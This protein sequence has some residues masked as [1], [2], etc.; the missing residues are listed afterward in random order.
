MGGCFYL[1]HSSK[2]GSAHVQLLLVHMPLQLGSM[3]QEKFLADNSSGKM[4]A[5]WEKRRSGAALTEEE[6]RPAHGWMFSSF[7]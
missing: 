1:L 6:V 4:Q 7:A 3:P 2:A 5:V